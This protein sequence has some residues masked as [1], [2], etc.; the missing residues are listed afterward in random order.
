MPTLDEPATL[1]DRAGETPPGGQ[2]TG[3]RNA[4]N[5]LLSLILAAMILLPI[6]EALLRRFH[7]GIEAAASLIQHLTLAVASLGGAIAAREDQLLRFSAFRLVEGATARFARLF[8]NAFSSG[9]A[10]L[11]CVA[12]VQFILVEHEG[13]SILAYGIPTWVYILVLPLGF[14]LIA[15]RL[16]HRAAENPRDRAI[17]ALIAAAL[18]AIVLAEPIDPAE[19]ALPLLLCLLGATLAG[20]PIFVA[21]GGAA[22]IL[23]WGDYVPLASLAVDYYGIATNPSL[24]AIPMFTLAGY[25][26]AES[27]APTR[28]LAVFH[29]L[30][31]RLQ[32]GAAI[33]AVLA[34]TFFTCFTGAS[35]VT[36]LALGG[37]IMPLLLDSG[38][39]RKQALGLVTAGGSAGVLLMPALPLILY[40]IVAK[41]EMEAMFVAGLLPALLMMSLVAAWGVKSQPPVKREPTDWRLVK[42]TVWEARWELALPLVPIG[43]L[44]SGLAT[45]VEA[46][47]LTA[48]YAFVLTTLIHRDLKIATDIPRVVS[49]CGL[50][51]GGILLI[52][53]VAL[54]LT[55]YMVDAQI[56]SKLVALISSS[57]EQRWVFLLALNGFLLLVGC[58]MDIF[59]AIVVLVPLIV[60]LGQVFG[61]NPM[62]LGLIFLANLELGYLTPP[63]GMNLFFSAMRFDKPVLEVCA[64]IV[65][66]FL[67]LLIGVLLITYIP[68]LSTFLPGLLY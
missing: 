21:V 16:L 15:W 28:L 26:L 44:F 18:V 64:S 57:I 4:E 42:R 49:R 50:V 68:S 24:P 48:L 8:A 36:I 7:F 39:G 30:F 5:I 40:A 38:L 23:L 11:L 66:I 33:V 61:I 53:G 35:G 58:F 2:R 55:N 32:G 59:S 37:L 27:K 31:G 6:A 14:V 65:P 67:M 22:L 3:L 20:A 46:A 51:V 41:V 17:A 62:H 29:G 54:G 63:V 34:A 56:S 47:A 25:F 19:L 52:L 13:G 10:A 12:G 9:V 60:P 1:A 45:P 43:V